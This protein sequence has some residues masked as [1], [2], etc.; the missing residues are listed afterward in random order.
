MD[1]TFVT[2]FSEAYYEQTARYSLETWNFLN[3]RKIVIADDGFNPILDGIEVVDSRKI[4]DPNDIYW[5]HRG[6]KHKFW[7][8]GMCFAWAAK[9]VTSKY[10]VWLDSDVKIFKPVDFEKFKPAEDILA[11]MISADLSHAE[12]GF[13]FLNREHT[14]F[15]KWINEYQDGWYNGL[16]E[17]VPRPWDGHI[18]YETIKKYPHINLA[19][20]TERDP[21]GFEDT[22]LLEYMFHYSGKNRKHLIKE[23]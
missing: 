11:T 8:K 5:Q 6:K 20:N 10:L 16:I 15:P 18:F 17:K 9:N 23:N 12:T 1:I 13:V 4:Y 21:Q 7:R 2:S 14:D 3:G 19:K 22:D